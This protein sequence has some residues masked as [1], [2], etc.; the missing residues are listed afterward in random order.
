MRV[1]AGVAKGRILKSV[2]GDTTRPIT[3]RTKEALFNIIGSDIVQASFLDCFAGTGSVGIEALSRGSAFARFI[4]QNPKAIQI[5][6]ENLK[7][8]GLIE[9]AEVIRMDA[10]AALAKQTDRRFDYI[11]VAPPQYH[12]LWSKM[13]I[14]LDNHL[15]WLSDDGWIIVQI[16][17]IEYEDLAKNQIIKNIEQFDRRKY[18]S[19]LLLFFER[20]HSEMG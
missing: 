2:E 14:L 8:T 12:G 5:I 3:D 7:T 15:E 9:K 20:A 19:T 4:D 17:P 13:L 1:I 18:G 6:R 10:F 11:Y 16:H